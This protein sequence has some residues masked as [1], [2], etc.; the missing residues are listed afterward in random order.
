MSTDNLAALKN[1]LGGEPRPAVTVHRFDR[2]EVKDA[3]QKSHGTETGPKFRKAF[4]AKGTS[5]TDKVKKKTSL[6]TAFTSSKLLN[7]A[8]RVLPI[9]KKP[10]GIRTD[11]AQNPVPDSTQSPYCQIG[12]CFVQ[13]GDSSTYCTGALVGPNAVLTVGNAIP[14]N[15][16]PWYMQFIPAYNNGT[17]PFG[18]INVSQVWGYNPNGSCTD[19]YLVCHLETSIGNELGYFGV[20]GS[21]NGGDYQ[22]AGSEFWNSVGYPNQTVQITATN[23]GI[24]NTGTSD[25]GGSVDLDTQVFIQGGWVGG[26]V[27]AQ[28]AFNGT[29]GDDGPFICGVVA[30]GGISVD[31]WGN[32]NQYQVNEG[33]MD[34]LS[35]AFYAQD[36]WL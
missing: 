2:R 35:L 12:I 4:N 30:G 18:V 15:S 13:S 9:T 16:T 32:V 19:D 11:F 33:G 3:L 8:T 24:D 34:M 28:Y 31:F 7:L 27:W 10:S 6:K 1:L 36:N 29:N 14:W 20:Y 23:F 25:Y 17:A 22:A 21:T 26:P 5:A